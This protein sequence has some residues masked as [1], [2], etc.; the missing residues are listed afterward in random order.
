MPLSRSLAILIV[1]AASFPQSKNRKAV[2]IAYRLGAT[3][4]GTTTGAGTTTGTGEASG[5]QVFASNCGSC[6]TLA[7]AVDLG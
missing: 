1:T 5:E 7:S 6:H 2:I 3:G 4:G